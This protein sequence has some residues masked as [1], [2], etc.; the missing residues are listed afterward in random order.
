MTEGI[1]RIRVLQVE[2][3]PAYLEK[4]LKMTEPLDVVLTQVKSV[5][6]ALE[7]LYK[8]HTF[9]NPALIEELKQAPP[10]EV[11]VADVHLIDTKTPEHVWQERRDGYLVAKTALKIGIPHAIIASFTDTPSQN[12]THAEMYDKE[13][14]LVRA[15]AVI[16]ELNQSRQR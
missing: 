2:D 10:F 5:S 8:G 7:L 4:F 14:G 12:I 3:E 1:E 11:V 9:I 16:Q 15:V 6:D 13:V